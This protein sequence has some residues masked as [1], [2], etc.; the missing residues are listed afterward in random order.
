[1]S[2]QPSGDN[3]TVAVQIEPLPQSPT[4]LSPTTTPTT[5]TAT[6]KS[7]HKHKRK[8]TV[9]IADPKDGQTKES[10]TASGFPNEK[11]GD[12]E[13][14]TEES[15]EGEDSE[16]EEE[17]EEDN[18]LGEVIKEEEDPEEKAMKKE[19]WTDWAHMHRP[20]RHLF[21]YR[22]VRENWHAMKTFL[23]R[24]FLILLIIPAWIVPNVLENQAKAAAAAAEGEGHTTEASHVALRYSGM[25]YVMLSSSEEE[26][27]E[28]TKG[29]YWAIFLLNLLVMV[30]LSKAAGA[31][32]EELVPRFGS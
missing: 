12:K 15:K 17:G 28:L 1:M 10:T 29:Q 21:P 7:G 14:I 27:P 5:T 2:Q 24:F 32:L 4:Q 31:A 30:H 19:T 23:R 3:D 6:K 9:R 11:A 22:S 13:E 18:G 8:S 26:G 25:K 20:D 16:E